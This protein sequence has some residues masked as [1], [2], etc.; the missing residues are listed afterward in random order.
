MTTSMIWQLE[1]YEASGL[2]LAKRP[3][4]K[5]QAGEV[6][7]RT[8]AVSL[9]YRDLLIVDG[10]L[11]S[12]P[13]PLPFVPTSDVAGAIVAVGEGVDSFEVGD[14][15]MGLYWTQWHDGPRPAAMLDHGT[16]LGGPLPGVLAQHVVLDS[17]AIVRVPR[18]LS[19][20]EASTL[21]IAA[22]TAWFALMEV[23]RILPGQFVV[24]QGTGGVSLF[25]LQFAR[26]MGAKVIVLT[27]SPEKVER[28][29]SLGAWHVIDTSRET[30]WASEVMRVTEGRGADHILE[31]VGGQNLGRSIAALGIN[32]S[33]GQIGFIEGTDSHVSLIPLMLKGGRINGIAV[34]HRRAFERM[35]EAVDALQIKPVI[36][37]VYSFDRVP[38]AFEHLRRGAFGKI[39]ISADS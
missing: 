23:E 38:E 5:P 20:A 7:V 16:S 29:K 4:P 27:R 13:P 30:D 9:N 22:L 37:R 19:L 8:G 31:V 15:V 39:V 32:G 12:D 21:P 1:R 18:S 28:V 2:T 17:Q 10:Q 24:V 34:G 3:V 6:V 14:S 25:G 33:I 26:G 11:L 35:C 36:E